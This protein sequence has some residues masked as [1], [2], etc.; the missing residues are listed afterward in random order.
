MKLLLDTHTL[1]WSLFNNEKLSSVCALIEN[2]DNDIFVSAA[3]LWEIEIKNRTNPKSMPYSAEEIF[4]ILSSYTDYVVLPITPQHIF[5]LK[6]FIEQ[7]IHRDPFDHL[8]LSTALSEDLVLLTHDET[9][10]KYRGVKLLS[11]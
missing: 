10:N 4:S 9:I 8:L 5:G 6:Q 7:G 11:F 1:I 3:S 2:K